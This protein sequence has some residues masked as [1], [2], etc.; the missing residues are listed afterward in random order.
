MSLALG[1]VTRLM[2]RSLY[3]VLNYRTSWCQKLALSLEALDEVQFWLDNIS[4]FNG[5]NIWPTPSA[6][7]VVYSDA[8]STGYGGYVVEHGNKVANGQW[9]PSEVVQ[10]STWR[11]LK[12]VRMVLESFQ[13]KLKNERVCVHRQPERGEDCPVWK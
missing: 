2:T 11:E 7:R 3:S 8:S 1:P 13:S 12:A 4:Q 10:S 5:R 9:S 6:V